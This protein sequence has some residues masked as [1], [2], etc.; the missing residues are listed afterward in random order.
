[1]KHMFDGPCPTALVRAHVL[2]NTDESVAS[3]NEI[4]FTAFAS[5]QASPEH[6]MIWKL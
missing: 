5:T 2:L 3:R 1:M 4:G 6:V